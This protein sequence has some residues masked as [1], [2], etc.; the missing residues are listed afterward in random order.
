[1][2]KKTKS[3]IK[4]PESRD[5]LINKTA[6]SKT[7]QSTISGIGETETNSLRQKTEADVDISGYMQAEAELRNA[8]EYAEN[9]IQTAN[10]IVVG[11][12]NKGN[13]TTFNKAAE[14]ITGYTLGEMKG[15][16]WFEVIVPR[17][18]YPSVWSVFEKFL[19]GELPKNFENHILTKSGEER[20]IVW[21][22]NEVRVKDQVVGTIS[23]GIDIT[24]R[25][26]AEKAIRDS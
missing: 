11:L 17:D 23:F 3:Q 15:R 9:L 21:Q 14:K 13:I 5:T 1:M 4:D 6:D 2:K 22:N 16:N 19:S 26:K 7:G 8:K 20:Y 12:D 25:K 18:H 24:E 10:T